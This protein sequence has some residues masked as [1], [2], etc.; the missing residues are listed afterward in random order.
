M[1]DVI[2]RAP[3]VIIEVRAEAMEPAVVRQLIDDW[4]GPAAGA[5]GPRWQDHA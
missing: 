4:S 2:A 1:E 5:G 3:D